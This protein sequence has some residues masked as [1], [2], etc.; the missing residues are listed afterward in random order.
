VCFY[1]IIVRWIFHD[2]HIPVTMSE[3]IQMARRGKDVSSTFVMVQKCEY[4]GCKA[5]HQPGHGMQ[6]HINRVHR[7]QTP[8]PFLDIQASQGVQN[9]LAIQNVAPDPDFINEMDVA[10][11]G[12]NDSESE[13]EGEGP[14]ISAELLIEN[15]VEHYPNAGEYYFARQSI[16]D[17]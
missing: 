7:L 17:R 3:T 6:K 14:P 4:D 2:C 9:I 10:F 13:E 12:D 11:F 8:Q 15:Q 1:L 5:W 16:T